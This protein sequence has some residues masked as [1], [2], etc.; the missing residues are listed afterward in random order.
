MPK[1][2]EKQEREHYINIIDKVL[3]SSISVFEFYKSIASDDKSREIAQK[4]IDNALKGK[5]KIKGIKHIAILRSLFNHI[6]VGKEQYY[7]MSGSLCSYDKIDVWDKTTTGY[8]QFLKMEKEGQEL[9]LKKQQEAQKTKEIV[10][11][12]KQEGKK[13]EMIYDDKSKSIKP[14]VVEEKPNA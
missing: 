11:K 9:A 13:V 4:A 10:E 7:A 14:V 8:R 1:L 6:V 12:A 5:D 3:D 2:T